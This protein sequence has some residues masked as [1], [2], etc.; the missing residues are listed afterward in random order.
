MACSRAPIV[1]W[2]RDLM[3][4]NLP[5]FSPGDFTVVEDTRAG[6]IVST[7]N[8]ISQTWSYEG[9]EFPAGRVDAVVT[10]RAYRRRGLSR[11]QMELLHR[12]SAGRG[13]KV[14]GI[15]AYPGTTGSSATS[16]RSTGR[17]AAGDTR[18]ARLGLAQARASRTASGR[19]PGRTFP[20]WRIS[21]PTG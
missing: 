15:T 14:I 5:G 11:A 7:L 13:E 4:G 10:D 19:R 2:T 16:S 8:L 12:W 6:R 18:A 21:T 17:A 3:E 20:W 1:T 9:I